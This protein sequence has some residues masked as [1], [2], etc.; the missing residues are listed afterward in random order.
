MPHNFHESDSVSNQFWYEGRHNEENRGETPQSFPCR[1]AGK[2]S[3][4]GEQMDYCSLSEVSHAIGFCESPISKGRV[5]DVKFTQPLEEKYAGLPQ[6]GIELRTLHFAALH[7]NHS[8][9]EE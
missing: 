4:S 1:R 8:T 3:A 6:V 7:L 2:R 9:T 5:C